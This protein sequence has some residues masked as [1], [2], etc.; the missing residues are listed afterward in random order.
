MFIIFS[1]SIKKFQNFFDP[2]NFIFWALLKMMSPAGLSSGRAGREQAA[3]GDD[4]IEV[5]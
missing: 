5:E 4:V 3:A 1:Q 2:Q